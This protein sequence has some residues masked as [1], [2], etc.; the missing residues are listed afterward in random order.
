VP[1]TSPVESAEKPRRARSLPVGALERLPLASV[2]LQY[3]TIRVRAES[4]AIRLLDSALLP[5]AQPR[6][7]R[8]RL[9]GL[10]ARL[11][12]SLSASQGALNRLS[13]RSPATKDTARAVNPGASARVA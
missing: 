13:A 8:S 10:R 2:K 9:T 6:A 4:E 7:L 3:L 11:A 12:K 1:D 5:R